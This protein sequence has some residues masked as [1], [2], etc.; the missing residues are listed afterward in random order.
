MPAVR[1]GNEPI[2]TLKEVDKDGVMKIKW[3]KKM[4]KPDNLDMI[5]D[6]EYVVADSSRRQLVRRKEWFDTEDDYL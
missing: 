5:K 4:R 1:T 3:D 6:A 2:P